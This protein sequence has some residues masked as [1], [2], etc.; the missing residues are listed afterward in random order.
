[1]AKGV[2]VTESKFKAIK[3]LLKSGA[4][5]A[6]ISESMQVSYCV[7]GY[8]KNSDTFEDY[9]H[10]SYVTSGGYRK[11]LKKQQEE[12]EKAAQQ[13]QKKAGESS[14]NEQTEEKQPQIVEHRQTIT[15]Q[16]FHFML[17]EQKKTNELLT[18]ISNK[19]A[20]IVAELTGTKTE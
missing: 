6:E 2:K 16:A 1:M 8:I 14:A 3:I 4:T 15:V 19:L 10:K 20:F 12:Q 18:L 5:Y 17:E 13:N 9:R 11:K 7:I